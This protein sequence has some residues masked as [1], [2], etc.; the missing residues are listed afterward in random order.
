MTRSTRAST[1]APTGFINFAE[2]VQDLMIETVVNLLG[3]KNP[4]T[5][6]T[7][8]QEPA[9]SYLEMHNEDDIF[10]YSSG[11]TLDA[12]ARPIAGLFVR[13]FSD[14]LKAKYGSEEK[15]RAA[16]KRRLAAGPGPLA[17]QNV[18][19]QLNPWFLGDDH[20]A[21]PEGRLSGSSS[22]IRPSSST[23]PRT[24][25][26]PSSSRPSAWRATRDRWSARAWQAPSMLPHY[27]NL[28]SDYLVGY[29]DRHNY[30]RRRTA[31]LDADQAPGSG[32]FSSGLQQVID[33]PFGLSEWITVYPSLYSAEGPAI[34]AA[35]GMGLQ[36]W[37]ASYEFQSSS[38]GRTFADRA[39]WQ[40]WGVWDAD[41]PTQ[42]GQFPTLARMIYRGDVRE[43]DVISVR[44]IHV[45]TT[46][47]RASSTSPTRSCSRATSSRSAAASRRKPWPRGRV[48][49]QFTDSSPALDAA[50]HGQVSPRR[51]DR[52]QHRAVGLGHRGQGLLHR[53][54]AG[55]EG[56][57]GL[58]RGPAAGPGRRDDHARLPL[59][60][61]RADGR[62]PG[63]DAGRREGGPSSRP[64]PRNCNTGFKYFAVDQ[65]IL[66][67]GK[68]PILL[69]PVKATIEL[70]GRPLAAVNVLDHDGRRTDKQLSVGKRPLRDRRRPRPRAL[71]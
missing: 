45:R 67:N 32:F 3:H 2:D 71:L 9:L 25:S 61:D 22:W 50:R 1:A 14:W 44:R 48:V 35:Y 47:A 17:K 24:A 56:R 54:H 30:F 59:R 68:A 58:R 28:R 23:R 40:P 12:S 27:D 20:S 63:R 38:A 41:V 31:G 49:V 51:D 69:E 21:R 65:K 64:S 8:A 19:P 13:Q 29:I 46:S 60:L 15:F 53:Q 7:Y 42:V 55:H 57:G 10:W 62:R 70:G 18:E 39:G 6:L 43:S 66:D 37:D 26:T 4:Y 33:R 36:G 52:L 16:W 34:V 5:G 11:G